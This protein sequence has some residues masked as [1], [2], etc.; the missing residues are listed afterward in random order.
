VQRVLREFSRSAV[1]AVFKWVAETVGRPPG[2]NVVGEWKAK[3][4]GRADLP[5][6]WLPRTIIV[7]TTAAAACRRR[8]N[9]NGGRPRRDHKGLMDK[10]GMKP[11]LAAAPFTVFFSMALVMASDRGGGCGCGR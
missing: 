7:P 1:C 4:G 9:E 8:G 10:G 2:Q 11:H 6:E 5:R 3:G